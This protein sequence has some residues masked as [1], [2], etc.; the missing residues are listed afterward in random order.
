M[1]LLFAAVVIGLVLNNGSAAKAAEGLDAQVAFREGVKLFRSDRYKEAATSF[2][3]AY[4]LKS[5]WKIQ[6]NIGQS[7]AAAAIWIGLGGV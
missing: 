3:K 7:E 2:R 5:N 6:Y 4:E 1:R